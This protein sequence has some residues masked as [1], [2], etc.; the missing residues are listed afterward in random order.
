MKVQYLVLAPVLALNPAGINANTSIGTA[1][2]AHA[3][4]QPGPS[5]GM[6]EP[7]ATALAAKSATLPSRFPANQGRSDSDLTSTN[8]A[9]GLQFIPVTPCRVAD[10]RNPAGPY[11]GPEPTADSIREFD[12]PQSAC[13]IPSTAV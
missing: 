8:G 3:N 1:T 4:S 12:I 7:R 10:T 2:S 13:N 11:G 6:L 5:Q 9:S